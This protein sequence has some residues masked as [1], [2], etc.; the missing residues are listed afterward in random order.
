MMQMLKTRGVAA[1][2]MMALALSLSAGWAV[3]A[4]AQARK[5][6]AY[7]APAAQSAAQPNSPI[8][9]E[10][11][12]QNVMGSKI[13]LGDGTELTIPA[14]LKVQRSDLKAGA[15]VKASYEEKG[16]QKVV[17]SITVESAGKP[18]K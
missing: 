14:G 16:G 17:T 5:E 13:T 11:K 9:I 8:M 15:S 10:G 6:P 2:A 3:D 4:L 18:A 7:P 1:A 12:I